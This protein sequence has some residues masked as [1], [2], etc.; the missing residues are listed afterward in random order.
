LSPCRSL[1]ILFYS[2]AYAVLA[3]L[4]RLAAAA[5]PRLKEQAAGRLSVPALARELAAA[6]QGARRCVVFSAPPANTSKLSP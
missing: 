2:L 6:R 1:L 4:L 5:V 3:P